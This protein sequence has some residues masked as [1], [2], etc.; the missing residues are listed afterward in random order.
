MTSILAIWDLPGVRGRRLEFLSRRLDFLRYAHVGV[1]DD[2]CGE[3]GVFC[4]CPRSCVDPVFLWARFGTSPSLHMCVY[5]GRYAVG[6]ALAR[7]LISLQNFSKGEGRSPMW[8]SGESVCAT[9]Q[10][11]G[12][13]ASGE[14]RSWTSSVQLQVAHK[15]FLRTSACRQAASE[16]RLS[17]E[18]VDKQLTESDSLAQRRTGLC[19]P[20]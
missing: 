7:L 20:F 12:Q 1:E 9:V 17:P 4:C 15:L 8:T 14:S 13:T 10:C 6:V 5:A 18:P 11:C 16:G 19:R 3:R 2:M